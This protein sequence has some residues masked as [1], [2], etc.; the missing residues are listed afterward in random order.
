MASNFD[1]RSN[2]SA[3]RRSY[4]RG[5][6]EY[7][8]QDFGGSDSRSFDRGAR[9]SAGFDF[10]EREDDRRF[11][12]SS[13]MHSGTGRG[14]S[15]GGGTRRSVLGGRD[16]RRANY[17]RKIRLIIIGI[18]VV[19]LGLSA[20]LVAVNSQL[21]EIKSIVATPTT[22][23][24]SE[25]IS[26]LAAVPEGS[27]LLS[28]NEDEIA[29]RIGTNPWVASV[30]VTRTFPNQLN[31]IVTEREEAAI[32]MLSNGTEAWR[33]S[34]DAHWIEAIAMQQDESAAAP[35]EQAKAQAE[36]DG[37]VLI[38]DSPATVSPAAGALSTDDTIVG[39]L[40]YMQQLPS[41]L[42]SQIVSYKAPSIQGIS[43]ILSNGVE[44]ALGSPNS[45]IAWKGQVALSILEENEG[46]ITYINVRTPDSPTWRGL[47]SAAAD[48]TTAPSDD[49]T[50]TATATDTTT[51]TDTT[52]AT[53]TDTA[54][55]TEQTST[56]TE[57]TA[58][59]ET[60]AE[61]TTGTDVQATAEG[62]GEA[63]A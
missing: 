43:A 58:T 50:D 5:K 6:G 18:V 52:T 34:T 4:E 36:A 30:T 42:T 1:R 47:D 21:F 12:A 46:Q 44:I 15:R 19:A 51:G 35:L 24:S 37:V 26:S 25:T 60:T 63:V 14:T 48:A 45:D 29:E 7:Y 56:G 57:G 39:V 2:F 11:D 38:T 61:G 31:I 9:D 28:I 53:A 8:G 16:P 41:A 23:I 32:V 10:A 22:H 55:T 40:A 54:T 49:G 3:S 59:T 62:T 27:T 13:R 17:N 33:L 20:Y